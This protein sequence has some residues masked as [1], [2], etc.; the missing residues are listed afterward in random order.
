VHVPVKCL[1]AECVGPIVCADPHVV[2]DYCTGPL[3]NLPLF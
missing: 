1:P 2:V 3:N